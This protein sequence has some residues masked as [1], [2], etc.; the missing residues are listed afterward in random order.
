VRKSIAVSVVVALTLIGVPLAAAAGVFSGSWYAHDA[1]L[2]IARGD[3]AT[4]RIWAY[5]FCPTPQGVGPADYMTMRLQLS[6]LTQ[7]HATWTAQARV[8]NIANNCRLS[9]RKLL[10]VGEIGQL[11]LQGG[12]IHEGLSGIR[13]CDTAEARQDVCGA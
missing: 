2:T 9:P 7:R 5:V 3:T 12:V 11:R 8:T 10:H 4:E 1:S 6:D 13:Y